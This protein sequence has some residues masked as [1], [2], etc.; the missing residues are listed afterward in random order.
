MSARPLAFVLL[1]M[2]VCVALLTL[3]AAAQASQFQVSPVRLDLS[4]QASSGLLKVH[5]RSA[6]PIRFQVTGFAWRQGPAGEVRLLR[7]KD[8]T[9]FPSMLT[10]QAG[11][12][13]KVRVGALTPQ[14]ATEQTY[15][16]IVE[17]LPPLKRAGTDAPNAVRVLTR[18][19]IPVF[20]AALAPSSRPTVDG[21][22]IRDGR[23]A[24]SVKNRGNTHFMNRAIRLFVSDSAGRVTHDVTTSGWY[25]LGNDSRS[26]DLVLPPAACTDL[27]KITV[28]LD[29]DKGAT[30]ATLPASPSQCSP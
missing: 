3:S 11:S 9:F 22:A 19:S 1:P 27:S 15:R 24:F 4:A 6:E 10:V 13:R 8:L 29:T 17:E 23:L 20:L 7:T 14:G 18:M 30:S 12:S 25:V 28:E 26:Y 2:L 21:L 5:N 16:V